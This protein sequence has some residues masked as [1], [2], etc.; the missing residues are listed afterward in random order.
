VYLHGNERFYGINYGINDLG[1]KKTITIIDLARPIMA[2]KQFYEAVGPI[3]ESAGWTW[4]Q[5]QQK[6]IETFKTVIRILQSRGDGTLTGRINF[7]NKS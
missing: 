7:P 2:V 1:S 5:V 6:E 4:D 3:Y